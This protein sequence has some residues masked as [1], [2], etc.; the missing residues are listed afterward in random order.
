MTA[1]G[2]DDGWARLKRWLFAKPSQSRAYYLGLW[3]TYVFV[4]QPV[5][6]RWPHQTTAVFL[7]L[8]GAD[9]LLRR[10]L[11]RARFNE[12][13]FIEVY[14]PHCANCPFAGGCTTNCPQQGGNR[15]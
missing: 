10:H 12:V 9:L 3:V 6:H 1:P 5:Y 7:A 4:V 8:L 13:D 14:R 2:N 15:A 11:N